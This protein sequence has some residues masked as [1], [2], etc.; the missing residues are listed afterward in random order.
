MRVGPS[1]PGCPP[2][3]G[4]PHLRSRPGGGVKGRGTG[5]PGIFEAG[6]RGG[7]TPPTRAERPTE[8]ID[9]TATPD[10]SHP[11]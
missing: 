9:L 8:A 7:L 6:A 3:P 10:T 11:D 4:A 5:R 2:L 1:S